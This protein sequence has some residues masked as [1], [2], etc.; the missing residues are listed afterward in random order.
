MIKKIVLGFV[1]V[2][3]LS[4]HSQSKKAQPSYETKV[5]NYVLWLESL[6]DHKKREESNKLV[7][8]LNMLSP[9][10]RAMWLT[11]AQKYAKKKANPEVKEIL[12]DSLSN[13]EVKKKLFTEFT[14]QENFYYGKIDTIIILNSSTAKDRTLAS[15]AEIRKKI[16]DWKVI[17][18]NAERE[19]DSIIKLPIDPNDYASREARTEITSALADKE[20]EGESKIISLRRDIITYSKEVAE[21]WNSYLIDRYEVEVILSVPHKLTNEEIDSGLSSGIKFDKEKNKY[22]AVFDTG[23]KN[24]YRWDEYSSFGL[25]QIDGDD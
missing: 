23:Y 3:G 25:N 9:Y 18:A 4:V 13:E 8:K 22:L 6:P 16:A 14:K 21:K 1:L 10:D 2:I 12:I 15:N 19:R 7:M 20:E 24:G 5:K 11:T 17:I